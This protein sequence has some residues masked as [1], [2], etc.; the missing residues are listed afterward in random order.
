MVVMEI[1]EICDLYNTC[2]RIS[3]THYVKSILYTPEGKGIK[4]AETPLSNKKISLPPKTFKHCHPNNQEELSVKDENVYASLIGTCVDYMSR[5]IFLKDKNAFFISKK[6]AEILGDVSGFNQ[7]SKAMKN[8]LRM[9]GKV[10]DKAIINAVQM[11]GYDVAYRSNPAGY[12]SVGT[13]VPDQA[14][15]KRIR[16]MLDRVKNLFDKISTPTQAGFEVS[17]EHL[18]IYG[19]GDFISDNYLLDFKTVVGSVSSDMVF[20]VLVYYILGKLEGKYSEFE[21]IRWLMIYNPRKDL[22]Y[23]CDVTEI[24]DVIKLLS[25]RIEYDDRSYYS[26]N[27]VR[28]Y[29]QYDG[30]YQKA[31]QFVYPTSSRFRPNI[32]KDFLPSFSYYKRNLL[33]LKKKI[34]KRIDELEK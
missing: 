22:L 3:V 1:E 11:C 15:I 33:T 21:K 28:R 34:E 4:V 32:N 16:V 17:S 8:S 9:A 13:I 23:Y 25:E 27:N 6:G 5:L 31:L 24:S 10:T 30:M 29:N 18:S 7:R 20:Q 26:D 19:D 12:K 2:K 14:T